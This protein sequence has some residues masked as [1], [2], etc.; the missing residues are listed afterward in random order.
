[1]QQNERKSRLA[2]YLSGSEMINRLPADLMAIGYIY[3]FLRFAIF[4]CQVL[5]YFEVFD[6]FH[7][8]ALN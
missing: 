1:V 5:F 2:L 3:I 7:V 4:Y 8:F 6:N